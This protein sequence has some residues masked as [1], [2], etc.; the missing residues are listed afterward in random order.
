MDELGAE[1]SLVIAKQFAANGPSRAFSPSPLASSSQLSQFQSGLADAMGT[2]IDLTIIKHRKDPDFSTKLAELEELC[3]THRFDDPH[4]GGSRAGMARDTY[5]SANHYFLEAFEVMAFS[6]AE[7]SMAAPLVFAREYDGK[8]SSRL[9][10]QAVSK[11]TI[12]SQ[13]AATSSHYVDR[14]LPA[15]RVD[16]LGTRTDQFLSADRLT[17]REVKGAP[18]LAFKEPLHALAVDQEVTLGELLRIQAQIGGGEHRRC[19]GTMQAGDDGERAINVV[20][21]VAASVGC[22]EQFWPSD[23][24]PGG[25]LEQAGFR[26]KGRVDHQRVN[27]YTDLGMA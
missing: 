10:F 4:F 1:L 8:L 3:R 14:V 6:V 13:L 20:L 7:V 27:L 16:R 12:F 25:R 5:R 23:L 21:P 24:N 9:F 19:P 22:R 18:V 17:L 26:L 2:N 15:L 11:S